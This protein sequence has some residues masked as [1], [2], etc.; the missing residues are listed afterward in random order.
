MRG[1]G[2]P[3]LLAALTRCEAN[4]PERWIG[5]TACGRPIEFP[6]LFGRG[7]VELGQSGLVAEPA[8]PAFDERN[9]V[10]D[11]GGVVG[12]VAAV[13]SDED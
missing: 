8:V 5:P 4:L 7:A 12:F 6:K 13:V 10:L 2:K 1:W 11:V 3:I 9:V